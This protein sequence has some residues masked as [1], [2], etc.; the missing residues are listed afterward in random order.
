VVA[1]VVAVLLLWLQSCGCNRAVAI[2]WLQSCGCNCVVAIM[3]LQ[4]CGCNR[5]VAVVVIVVVVAAA[6]LWS[7]LQLHTVLAWHYLPALCPPPPKFTINR[8]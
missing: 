5:A 1:V 6:L 8:V 3:W 4:S 2:M 7:L